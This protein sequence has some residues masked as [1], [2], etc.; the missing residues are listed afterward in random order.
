MQTNDL[1]LDDLYALKGIKKQFYSEITYKVNK[2]V[3]GHR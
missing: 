3:F 2:E 1:H